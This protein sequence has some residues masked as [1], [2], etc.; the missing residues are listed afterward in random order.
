MQ[1]PA[2]MLWAK[3]LI[4]KYSFFILIDFFSLIIFLKKSFELILY[5]HMDLF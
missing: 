1:F 3:I 5:D 4:L 2:K